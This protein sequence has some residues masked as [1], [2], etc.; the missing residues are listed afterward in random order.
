MKLKILLETKSDAL[1]LIKIAS[2]LDDEITLT[3][4]KGMVVNAKSFLGTLYAKFEFTEIW[5]ESKNDHY[6]EFSKFA[7]E[8]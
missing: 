1:D 8:E 5:L 2:L 4:G 7:A 6:L 3:D